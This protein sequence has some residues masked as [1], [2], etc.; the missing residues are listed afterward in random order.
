MRVHIRQFFTP[1]MQIREF[2]Q[3]TKSFS[4]FYNVNEFYKFLLFMI[5]I[6]VNNFYFDQVKIF[7]HI[8]IFRTFV[9]F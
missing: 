7:V 4:K 6:T 1:N 3:I 8:L 9:A 2:Y 5:V